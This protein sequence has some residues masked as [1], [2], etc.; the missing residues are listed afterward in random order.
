MCYFFL[1][2]T[3]VVSALFCFSVDDIWFHVVPGLFFI[4]VYIPSIT[5][6]RCFVQDHYWTPIL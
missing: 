3:C 5:F 2:P 6:G 4:H 1:T